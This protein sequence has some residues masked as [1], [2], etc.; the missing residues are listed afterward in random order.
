MSQ[1]ILSI[2]QGTTSSRAILFD[3]NGHARFT[4]QREFTQHFPKD[5][6]V[7]HD[8]EEIWTT[9]LEVV[10]EALEKAELEQR[11]IAAIGI[12]NQRE[13]WCGTA[14]TVNRYTTRSYGRTAAPPV[15]ASRCAQKPWNPSS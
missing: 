5:G 1:Y 13:T 15:T 11:K 10:N 7:E 8:P 3:E 9:T 14:Q 12:T 4:A 2:D 6:W